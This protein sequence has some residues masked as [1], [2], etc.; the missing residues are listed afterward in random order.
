MT[1]HADGRQVR[2]FGHVDDVVTALVAAIERE[3][4]PAGPL[5]LGG[6]ARTSIE[7]LARIV[8]EEAGSRSPI[9]HVDP[10]LEAADFEEVQHR[11]PSLERAR[12]LGLPLA[13]R[14]MREIVRDTLREWSL[15][16]GA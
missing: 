3:D 15:V 10:R 7:R 4:F 14:S 16:A 5:N 1:V 13:S 6:S 9:V 8:V 12:R 11:E 2:T